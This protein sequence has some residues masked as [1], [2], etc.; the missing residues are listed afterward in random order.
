MTC[1]LVPG[2]RTWSSSTDEDNNREYKLKFL[3]EC[4]RGDGPASVRL[5]PGFPLVGS[6]WVYGN[7]V[8]LAAWRRPGDSI[9]PH[10]EKEGDWVSVWAVELT[11]S[12]KPGKKCSEQQFEDPLT[13]PPDV[14]G[15]G[16]E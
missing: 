10:E 7:D 2:L 14:S 6:P 13:E 15:T 16:V 11:F 12:T 1:R 4:D 9:T 8:D 5:T 3:V